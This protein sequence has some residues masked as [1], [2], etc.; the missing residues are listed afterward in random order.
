MSKKKIK[1]GI[2]SGQSLPINKND[3]N[4]GSKQKLTKL[5]RLAHREQAQSIRIAAYGGSFGNI[6]GNSVS[7]ADSA[8]YSPQ[9]STDFLELPQS[10]REKRELFRFWYCCF[11]PGAPITLWDGT[12][13]PI[14]EIRIGDLVSNGLGEQVKVK[15]VFQREISD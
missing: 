1:V 5:E 13:I 10:E 14:E 4:D 2:V 11:T 3:Q 8:F 12:T 7:N 6:G 15:S 9:L